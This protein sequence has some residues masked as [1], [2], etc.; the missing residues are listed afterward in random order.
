MSVTSIFLAT[1]ALIVL[2]LLRRRPLL[3]IGIGVLVLG[4]NV[5][6]QVLKDGLDRPDLSTPPRRTG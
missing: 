4:A 3:A 5:T 6:T 2:A 1:V